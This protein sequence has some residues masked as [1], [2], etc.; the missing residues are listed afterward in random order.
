[1]ARNFYTSETYGGHPRRYE[2]L[3]FRYTRL[4]GE[5]LLVNEAGEYEFVPHG[6][7]RQLVHHRLATGTSLYQTVK[8]KHFLFDDE[9]APLLDVLA[10]KCRTKR[11]FLERGVT[12]H[13]MVLTLR[14]GNSCQ[15]CQVSRQAPD[16]ETYDMSLASIE[17]SLGFMMQ[18][19]GEHL[20]LEF[21]GGE[22]LLAFDRLQYAVRTAKRLAAEHGKALS[23]VVCTSL[24]VATDEMLAY[25][26]D[27][28]IR[29][30][31]SLDGPPAVHN[32]NRQQ[33]GQNSYDVTVANIDRARRYVGR[34]N[35]GALMTTS[36]FSLAYPREIVDEYVRLGFGSIFLRAINPYG[37]A[38]KTADRTGY[39]AVEFLRFYTTA[40]D[41]IIELNRRGTNLVEIYAKL[42]LTKI[43]TPYTTGYVDLQSPTGA[44]VSVLVYNYDGDIY[45]S[46]E[47]RMLAEMGDQAFRLGN[48]YR[49]TYTSMVQ[50]SAY[51]YL[52]SAGCSETLPG[53][54]DCAYQTYCG[55]DPVRHHA[56]QHDA[57]GHRPTS[58]F[59]QKN[60]G[61]ITHLFR[62]LRQADPA[63]L[64][65]LFLWTRDQ[66]HGESHRCA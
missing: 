31:T 5:E 46:D 63:L 26:R 24:A 51:Q 3:P 15:Y 18:F 13:I 60:M 38:L 27:Q 36:R 34:D 1:M 62:L 8:A 64:R 23:I 7:V 49:D 48:V 25:L 53:C 61:I 35:V 52:L 21:Q 12:L 40:L 33:P 44:G 41:Y 17:R 57:F 14:C 4:D 58:S 45:A 43:L 22:P 20:T 54:A 56:T 30:S 16:R 19:P 42:I 39:G 47:S 32:A 59:C 55:A 6:S 37:F 28:E 29:I 10:T 9:S 65:I 50:G 11:A 66:A 2:L